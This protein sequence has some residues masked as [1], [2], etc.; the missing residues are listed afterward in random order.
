MI[1]DGLMNEA[2]GTGTAASRGLAHLT[3]TAATTGLTSGFGMG[4]GLT[5]SLWPAMLN[6][7]Q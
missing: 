1:F 6:Y 4:P 5:L 2:M 7:E 3:S